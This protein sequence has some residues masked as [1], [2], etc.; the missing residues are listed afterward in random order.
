MNNRDI[1]SILDQSLS[2]LENYSKFPQVLQDAFDDGLINQVFERNGFYICIF[3]G[4]NYCSVI[5]D[6]LFQYFDCENYLKL[7]EPV[8]NK[9]YY[10]GAFIL[11]VKMNIH[12]AIFES[13]IP[14]DE[15]I[16]ISSTQLLT[17]NDGLTL[18]DILTDNGIK[19]PYCY[20]RNS[21]CWSDLLFDCVW[22]QDCY[23][24]YY[25]PERITG[26]HNRDCYMSIESINLQLNISIEYAKL[27]NNLQ[28]AKIISAGSNNNSAKKSYTAKSSDGFMT[29]SGEIPGPVLK[30]M[31]KYKI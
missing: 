29:F 14:D 5:G 6:T 24:P 22:R 21:S 1:E 17:K 10:V 13:F 15:K 30:T 31:I 19:I 3:S 18:N 26:E 7:E 25:I 11:D 4:Y 12:R 23:D 20:T 28:C 8:L 27:F 16:N 9:M 2:T